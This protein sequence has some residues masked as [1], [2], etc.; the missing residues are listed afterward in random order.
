MK[1]DQAKIKSVSTALVVV[2]LACFL[3]ELPHLEPGLLFPINSDALSSM[4]ANFGPL[5][6]LE[7]EYWR[8]LSYGFLHSNILHLLLN[9]Y[10]LF[11]FGPMAESAIGRKTFIFIYLFTGIIGGLSSILFDPL[12][13]SVGASA[14][15]CGV[16]GA[17]I[18]VS[19]FKREQNNVTSKLKRPEL[20]LLMVFLGYSLIL[21][22]TSASMDNAAHI[23]GFVSGI[24]AAAI[25]TLK[26]KKVA[27]ATVLALIAICPA[28]AIIDSKR[29]D[30]NPI[31]DEFLLRQEGAKFAKKEEFQLAINKFDQALKVIADEPFA[32]QGRGEAWMKLEQFEAA[33]KDFDTI[34]NKDPNHKGALFNRSIALMHLGRYQEGLRDIDK[35]V[36]LDKSHSMVYNNRAW[37]RLNDFNNKESVNLAMADTEQAIK[38]D[39]R[40]LAAYDTR[41]T[42]HLIKGD[43]DKAKADYEKCVKVKETSGAAN[44]HLAILSLLQNNKEEADK[45]LVDYRAGEYKPDD[46]ELKYCKEKLGLTGL[47]R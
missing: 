34:L 43:Y 46:F 15:I 8:L 4:G 29:M 26:Q 23:G 25:L 37:F 5:T 42:I 13:T 45:R 12:R 47:A 10:A 33:K 32:L 7:K 44:F 36:S 18:F 27:L 19:W 14:S 9:A 11:E 6:I 2:I 41:G 20:I 17:F 3:F 30:K 35:L 24:L 21:G 1:E 39:K 31:V 40:N 38:L 28:M 22:F 16:L